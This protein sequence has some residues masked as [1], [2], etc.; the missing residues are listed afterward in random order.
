VTYPCVGLRQG[1][2]NI[3]S[4]RPGP[5]QRCVLVVPVRATFRESDQVVH[6][7]FAEGLLKAA[8]AVVF[9]TAVLWTLFRVF[10]FL[11]I[12]WASATGRL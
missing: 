5:L 7:K 9:C 1:V 8:F 3:T 11:V 4:P 6:E 10:R 12:F 2:R